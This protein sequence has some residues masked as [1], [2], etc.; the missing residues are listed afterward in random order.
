MTTLLLIRHGIAE[1]PRPGQRDRDRAL[2]EEGWA[3]TRAA[4]KG[5]VARGYQPSH[6]FSSSYRR[7]LETMTCLKEVAADFPSTEWAGL[8]PDGDA[9]VTENWLRGLVAE[10]GPGGVFAITSHQPFLGDLIYH[11]TG[12]SLEVKKASCTVLRW[13]AGTWQ[14]EKHFTPSELREG[15]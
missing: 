5:L 15:R 8:T 10:A 4:M 1:D 9:A 7:A 12:R 14:F 6:G 11:L 2:T 13:H 3:K